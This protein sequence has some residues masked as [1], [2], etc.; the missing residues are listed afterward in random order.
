MDNLISTSTIN[1]SI[2]ESQYSEGGWIQW[3][4]SLEDHNFFCEVD[5]EYI[6]DNFNLYGLRQKFTHYKS[7]N[8][9]RVITYLLNSEA[10]EMIL[11][12]ECPDDEDL[13]DEK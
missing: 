7:S 13:E 1:L 8:E 4:C 3:F 9:Y 11:S 5:E 10:L 6:R 2:D 12:P